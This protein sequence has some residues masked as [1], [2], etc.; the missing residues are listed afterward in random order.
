MFQEI[1][2]GDLLKVGENEY[3][4]SAISSVILEFIKKDTESYFEFLQQVKRIYSKDLK[5]FVSYLT[6]FL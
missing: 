3:K 4:R 2:L 6:H 1:A 5:T